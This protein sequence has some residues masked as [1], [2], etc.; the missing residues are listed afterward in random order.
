ML[1]PYLTFNRNNSRL[2]EYPTLLLACGLSAPSLKFTARQSKWNFF[3]VD[4]QFEKL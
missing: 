1:I 3:N 2:I 4:W